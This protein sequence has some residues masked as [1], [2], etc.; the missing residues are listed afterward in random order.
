MQMQS[1]EQGMSTAYY[2]RHE[3]H[4]PAIIE[5]ERVTSFAQLN[6]RANQLVR[7]LRARGLKAGDSIAL[8]CSNRAEFVE[9]SVA[10]ERSGLRLTPL[11]THLTG[12]E[13]GYILD[14][15]EAR[16]LLAEAR[17]APQVQVAV[18]LASRAQ[19]KLAIGGAIDGFERYEDAL[20]VCSAHDIE[21]PSL[22][23]KMLYTSGTTGRPKGVYRDPAYTLPSVLT[24]LD[25]AE[26]AGYK[27]G[28]NQLHLCAGPLYHAAPFGYSMAQPLLA[29]VGLVLMNR[30]DSEAA[31]RLIEQH[32]ITH[33]HM[34]PTMFHRLLSLP[35][36]VKRKY[37]LSSLKFVIH[38]AAPCSVQLKAEMIKWWGPILS[39]YYAA[40][41]GRAVSVQSADWLKRPGTVGKPNPADQVRILDEQGLELPAAAAGTIY[42]K[43][44]AV[45]RF[46]YFKDEDKTANSYRGDYFTLGDIG[47]LDADGW[48][49]L[50][51][52]NANL[53]ISGGVNIYPTEIEGVL[54]THPSV[55]DVG[56]IGVPNEEWGE[57]VKAVIELQTGVAESSDLK[58]E[59]LLFCK[60]HLATFKCPR[61][62]DFTQKLPRLDNGKLYKQGLREQYRAA[63][64]KSLTETRH[65]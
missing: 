53:I 63:A 26:A 13:L 19:V 6:A 38:G 2:A 15:C 39:E 29:G 22:G 44:P 49:F 65:D 12:E 5:A 17:Y 7:A 34:V 3:G 45:G 37:D 8:L 23:S 18:S 16:A 58:A 54:L 47:Y 36:E 9:A 10:V 61:S 11:N 52:R 35:A 30:W 43:A 48:L 14:N 59:L 21:D 60:E 57:E 28:C 40:T 31:L 42:I 20:A 55:A 32:R 62:I 46:N 1:I 56:V 27:A 4:Q 25:L 24:S 41:E 50:T 64:A 33:T 51:D